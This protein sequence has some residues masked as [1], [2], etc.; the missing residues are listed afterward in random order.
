MD[1]LKS[2]TRILYVDDEQLTRSAFAIQFK[3]FGYK[4]DLA[5]SG[6]DALKKVE[7]HPYPLVVTDLR[8]PGMGGLE[9]VERLR[10]LAPDTA[11][12]VVT[13]VPELDLARDSFDDDAIVAVHP[14]PWDINSLRDAIERGLAYNEAKTSTD[15]RLA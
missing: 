2:P 5:S 9:L 3:R 13:G 6:A 1:T 11:F 14:K 4:I 12:I 7:A 15:L 10:A 8:M